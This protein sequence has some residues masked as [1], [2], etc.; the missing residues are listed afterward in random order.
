[1]PTIVITLRD[2]CDLSAE[3]GRMRT[4]FDM[5]RYTPSAFKYRQDGGA[6]LIQIDVDDE[7]TAKRFKQSFGESDGFSFSFDRRFSRETMET[8]YWWRLRPRRSGP[9]RNSTGRARRKK[10][11]PT[12]HSLTI[13]WPRISKGG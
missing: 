2:G 9:R 10:R 7:Q 11:W 8:V 1:M 3:M 5:Q 6:I 13:G 4:W 12:S